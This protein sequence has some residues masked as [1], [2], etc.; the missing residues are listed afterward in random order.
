M[1]SHT[2]PIAEWGPVGGLDGGGGGGGGAAGTTVH[3]LACPGAVARPTPRPF[4]EDGAV[5]HWLPLPLPWAATAKSGSADRPRTTNSTRTLFMISPD[6][7]GRGYGTARP[8][9]AR[10]APNLAQRA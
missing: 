3:F 2:I 8:Q 1:S 5:L 4:G 7:R 9:R 6:R 10:T